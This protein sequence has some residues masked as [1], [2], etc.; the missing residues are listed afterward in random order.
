[1]F[2]IINSPFGLGCSLFVLS[3]YH[4]FRICQGVFEKKFKFFSGEFR[5][6]YFHGRLSAFMLKAGSS[7]S[8]IPFP[9]DTYI[10]PQKW[11]FVKGFLK[12]FSKIFS[13]PFIEFRYHCFCSPKSI[14]SKSLWLRGTL[15]P[16]TL[17]LY[18]ISGKMSI[19]K[20]HKL[21]GQKL[22]KLHNKSKNRS[23]RPCASGS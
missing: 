16:L 2:S 5:T 22:C 19:G 3:L 13:E 4:R 8:W 10:I 21:S 15:A 23:R 20:L 9:L 12:S 6:Y 18:H 11:Q 14:L 7:L 17:I 1:M